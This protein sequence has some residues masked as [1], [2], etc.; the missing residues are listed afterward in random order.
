MDAHSLVLHIDM[1]ELKKGN[2]RTRSL[3]PFWGSTVIKTNVVLTDGTQNVLLNKQVNAAI[4]FLGENMDAG[5]G[6]S[7]NIEK[8]LK[9]L[10]VLPPQKWAEG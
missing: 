7:R 2:E 5:H 1:Q 3:V 4:R 6:L 9:A 10:P 8:Q